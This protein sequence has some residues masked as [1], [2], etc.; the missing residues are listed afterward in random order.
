MDAKQI[1]RFNVAVTD[2][3]WFDTL[4]DQ[5][6]S[7]EINFWQPSPTNVADP[8]GTPWLFKLHAPKNVIV[9]GAFFIHYAR[10]PIGIAWNTF[11][12]RNGT[13]S[14]E[15]MLARV[16]RYRKLTPSEIKDEI[17]CVVLA[18]PF[19]FDETDWVQVPEDWAPNIVRGKHYDL[20]SEV[21]SRLW[22]QISS[23]MSAQE[24]VASPLVAAAAQPALGKPLLVVPRLGQ[25]SFRLEVLAAYELRCAVTGERTLPVLEAAHIKPFSLV[26]A[27][28]VDNGLSLRSDIHRLYDQGYVS[29]TPDLVFRVSRRL[30][31]EYHN[32][33]IY[34]DLEGKPIAVPKRA[35]ARP[36]LEALDWHYSTLFKR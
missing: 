19:F 10:L 32:G 34:Y 4:R 21:G 8:P 23:R 31:D 36:N 13:E 15:T 17:G 26:K 20:V 22:H 6:S 3:D 14:F 7:D 35:E 29:V 28:S 12:V 25:S 1:W 5:H 27:H 9:G 24:V 33:R 16:A 18:D 2:E 30:E 11:G